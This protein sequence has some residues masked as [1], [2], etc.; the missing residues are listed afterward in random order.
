MLW[1]QSSIS[2]V[3]QELWYSHWCTCRSLYSILSG[4]LAPSRR[5]AENSVSLISRLSVSPNSYCFDEPDAS[6]PV[7]KSRV[8][9]RPK[10]DFPSDPSRSFSVLNPRKSSDLSVTSKRTLLSGPLPMPGEPCCSLPGCST[11]ICPSS[12]IFC[13]RLSRSFCICSGERFC[14]RS[15]ISRICSLSKRSPCSSACWMAFFKSSSVCSFH[16]LKG[17]YCVLNPLC[18]R[19][20]ESACNRSSAPMP[21]SSPVY[22]EYLIFIKTGSGFWVLAHL[23]GGSDQHPAPSTQHPISYTAAVRLAAAAAPLP[24]ALRACALPRRTPAPRYG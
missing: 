11:V 2:T 21:K 19:K 10:L 16:S 8:S 14:R 4:T 12:I 22:L 23:L 24:A 20:S 9:C 18:R 6:M 15:I 17:M 13:T 1:L 5:I 7:A 3:A